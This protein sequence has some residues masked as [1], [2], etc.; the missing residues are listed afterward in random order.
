[1]VAETRAEMAVLPR[2]AADPLISAFLDD[3]RKWRLQGKGQFAY[4]IEKQRAAVRSCIRTV[5]CPDRAGECAAFA[6]EKF[7]AGQFRS[8]RGAVDDH[9]LVAG[10]LRVKLVD[11]PPDQF[12][13]GTA[14]SDQEH[15]SVREPGDFDNLS[16][17]G[18]PC[19]TWD[20]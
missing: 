3:A 2:I 6:A 5:T 15:R 14:F 8:D 7:T 16:Q 10:Y 11:E 17:G 13:T 12:L 18:S 19:G 20:A 1:L 4:L 9:K